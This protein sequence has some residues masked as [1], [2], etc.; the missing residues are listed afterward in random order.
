[1]HLPMLRLNNF[2]NV[3]VCR[4]NSVE[5]SEEKFVLLFQK[6]AGDE[7]QFVQD[8]RLMIL[9]NACLLLVLG[10]CT[11]SARGH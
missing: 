10:R 9:E 2:I 3:L 6:N 1:M 7:I 4:A 5:I 11:P 8:S